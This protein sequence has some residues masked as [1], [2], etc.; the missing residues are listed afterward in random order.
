MR[1]QNHIPKDYLDNAEPA[2]VAGDAD[3][4]AKLSD[5][6]E[7]FTKWTGRRLVGGLPN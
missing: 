5:N 1:G 3:L 4:R 2:D 7:I 6:M